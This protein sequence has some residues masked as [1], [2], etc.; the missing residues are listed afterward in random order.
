M[1]EEDVRLCCFLVRGD[2]VV[3]AEDD[4]EKLCLLFVSLVERKIDRGIL[5]MD[6]GEELN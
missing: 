5:V 4:E 6:E 1:G 3:F 2:G